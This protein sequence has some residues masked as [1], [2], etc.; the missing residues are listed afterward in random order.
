[1]AF[2]MAVNITSGFTFGPLLAA[3]QSVV[4]PHMRASA[5]AIVGF[6]ASLL[7]V[8]AGPFLVGVL[9][10]WFQRSMSEAD[11]LQLALAI[12][13]CATLVALIHYGLLVK[14]FPNDR[15]S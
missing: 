8:G 1:M 7:G 5:S 11:A 4:P 10:E 6:T 15:I 14:R 3:T 12:V 2:V 13:I 9:S